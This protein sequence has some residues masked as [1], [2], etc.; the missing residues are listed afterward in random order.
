[1]IDEAVAHTKVHT[2]VYYES[3]YRRLEDLPKE[4]I[5]DELEKI[6]QELLNGTFPY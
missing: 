5:R 2:N 1:M 4:D 3:V 6:S